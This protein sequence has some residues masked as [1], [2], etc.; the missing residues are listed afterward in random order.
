MVKFDIGQKNR[1]FHVESDVDLSGLKIGDK[2]KGQE[3]NAKFSDY[4]FEITGLSDTSGFPSRKDVEGVVKKKILLKKGVGMREKGKGLI[5]RKL[6]RGNTISTDTAQINLKT[7]KE[8][9]ESL[10]KL[11]G[12]EEKD[13]ENPSAKREVS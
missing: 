5:L 8:G 4:E 11:L 9:K 1:T 7:V 13:L 6:V 10:A 2:V 12:K 3:I